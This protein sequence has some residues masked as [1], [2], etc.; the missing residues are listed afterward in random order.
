MKTTFLMS[1]NQWIVN[2]DRRVR[3]I[4][5]RLAITRQTGWSRIYKDLLP[6]VWTGQVEPDNYNLAI[7]HDR[8]HDIPEIKE[9]VFYL[10]TIRQGWLSVYYVNE[11]SV[12]DHFQQYAAE[13]RPWAIWHNNSPQVRPRRNLVMREM[14]RRDNIDLTG[15]EMLY[16]QGH[17]EKMKSKYQY[18]GSEQ[19]A[20]AV[21]IPRWTPSV[22]NY[23]DTSDDE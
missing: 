16:H 8:P 15:E 3:L 9:Q 6:I 4:D 2:E 10:D 1:R 22:Y 11:Q 21:G 5:P 7:Y 14:T 20:Q 13:H 17:Y 12:I 23:V 18:C 19:F